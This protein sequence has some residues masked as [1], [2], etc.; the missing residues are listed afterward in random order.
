[1]MIKACVVVW[2]SKI[3]LSSNIIPPVAVVAAHSANR[4]GHANNCHFEYVADLVL[5]VVPQMGVISVCY[6]KTSGAHRLLLAVL[7]GVSWRKPPP[8]RG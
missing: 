7:V 5:S 4:W 8:Y 3:L 1:M 6:E 2:L